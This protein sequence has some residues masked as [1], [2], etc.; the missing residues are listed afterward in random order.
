[1]FDAQVSPPMGP[2]NVFTD[3]VQVCISESPMCPALEVAPVSLMPHIT[4]SS[5]TVEFNYSSVSGFVRL[6]LLYFASSNFGA[7]CFFFCVSFCT[8]L[9]YF[10]WY[11]LVARLKCTAFPYCFTESVLDSRFFRHWCRY[12]EWVSSASA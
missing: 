12:M 9:Y 7:H 4:V 10:C 5:N 6:S 3:G 2:W 11:D 8:I 1:M